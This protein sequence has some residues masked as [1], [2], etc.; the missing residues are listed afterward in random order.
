MANEIKTTT[1][2]ISNRQDQEDQQISERE[3]KEIQIYTHT[4]IPCMYVRGETKTRNKNA[5]S[6]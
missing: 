5:T 2:T 4:Y 6:K 3:D 1:D